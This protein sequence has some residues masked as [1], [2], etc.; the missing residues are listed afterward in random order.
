MSDIDPAPKH[1]YLIHGETLAQ[2]T[3]AQEISHRYGWPVSIP[4]LREVVKFPV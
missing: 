3:L 4:T 1:V 2:E